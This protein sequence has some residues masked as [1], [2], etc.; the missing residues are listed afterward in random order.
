VSGAKVEDMRLEDF[1]F[2]GARKNFEFKFQ[3]EFGLILI[4]FY[5]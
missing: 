3:N 4:S 1:S 2:T 5:F